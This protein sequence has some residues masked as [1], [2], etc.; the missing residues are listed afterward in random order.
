MIIDP[1]DPKNHSIQS[2]CG[3]FN[4]NVLISQSLT[5][6]ENGSRIIKQLAKLVQTLSHIVFAA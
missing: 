3:I 5:N 2:N 1:I 4:G 6:Q